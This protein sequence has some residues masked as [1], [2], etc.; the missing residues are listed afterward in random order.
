M[1]KHVLNQ[2]GLSALIGGEEV[3]S[4]AAVMSRVAK[5]PRCIFQ[6]D[7][8]GL[9]LQKFASPKAGGTK[10]ASSQRTC[11]C[12]RATQQPFQAPNTPSETVQISNTPA[13]ICT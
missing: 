9:L 11:A 1:V 10:K 2:A 5:S 3:K 7:E 8:F 6:L 13:C 4:D 12:G